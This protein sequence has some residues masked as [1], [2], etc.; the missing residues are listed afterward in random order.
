MGLVMKGDFH[1]EQMDDW[2]VFLLNINM[3][4]AL[5]NMVNNGD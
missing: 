2:L 5:V 1:G 4:I 3:V